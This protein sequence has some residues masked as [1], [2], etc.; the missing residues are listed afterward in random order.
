MKLPL[1]TYCIDKVF[2]S[3]YAITETNTTAAKIGTNGEGSILVL[4]VMELSS[5]GRP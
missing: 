3:V 1:S 2:V 4:V 5:V